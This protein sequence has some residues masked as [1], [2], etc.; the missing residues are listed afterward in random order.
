MKLFPTRNGYF[1]ISDRNAKLL[2]SEWGGL[3]VR[4][5]NGIIVRLPNG[6]S[7]NLC[8][9]SYGVPDSSRSNVWC[10]LPDGNSNIG[11]GTKQS[12]GSFLCE[13]KKESKK[14]AAEPP[15][16]PP[17]A[18][19]PPVVEMFITSTNT[20]NI[21]TY[22]ITYSNVSYNTISWSTSII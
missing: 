8:R 5:V 12:D 19:P 10:V 22:P 13:A 9:R 16:E 1:R 15:A 20:N 14:D 2:S 7:A 17:P 21:Y 11:V 6:C 3:P 18:E 4:G